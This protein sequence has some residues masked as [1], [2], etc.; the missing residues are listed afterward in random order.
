MSKCP[1]VRLNV[2]WFY[3]T[4]QRFTKHTKV[5][6]PAEDSFLFLDAME[7]ELDTLKQS[8]PCIAVEVIHTLCVH[9]T[10]DTRLLHPQHLDGIWIGLIQYR[11][12]LAPPCEYPEPWF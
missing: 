1:N 10:L 4:Y 2:P 6:E 12:P 5:Y 7:L 8:D 9:W 11:L 3:Q